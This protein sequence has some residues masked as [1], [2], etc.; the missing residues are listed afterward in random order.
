LYISLGSLSEVETLV[1]ISKE[2][3]FIKDFSK[4]GIE[5]QLEKVKSMILGLIKYLKRKTSP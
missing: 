4:K 5:D 1:I 2:L 3:N